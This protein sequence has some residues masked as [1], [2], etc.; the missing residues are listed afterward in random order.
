MPSI[1]FNARVN[2]QPDVEQDLL[3]MKC[4][5]KVNNELYVRLLNSARQLRLVK[6]SKARIV[7][8]AAVPKSRAKPQRSLVVA[9][10]AMVGL[11]AARA[12]TSLRI[13]Y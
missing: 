4:D 2:A 12:L 8:R 10:A 3:R 11:P 5:V 9:L 7:D 6:E 1:P 13:K